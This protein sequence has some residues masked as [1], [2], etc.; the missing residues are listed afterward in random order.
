[1]HE[2]MV[3]KLAEQVRNF[4]ENKVAFRIFHGS[5][6]ST[7]VQKFKRAETL[8]ASQLNHV[9]SIN[10]KAKTAIV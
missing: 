7:R 8:D 10:S 5:T 1:M 2:A 4:Y 3:A 9:L 6:N